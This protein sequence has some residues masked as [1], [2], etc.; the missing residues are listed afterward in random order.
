MTANNE[1]QQGVEQA[2]EQP[3][4]QALNADPQSQRLRGMLDVLAGTVNITQQ[5]NNNEVLE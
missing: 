4:T 3:A 1:L 2:I 5:E